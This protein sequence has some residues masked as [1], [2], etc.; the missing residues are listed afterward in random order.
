[1]TGAPSSPPAYE[2]IYPG[3][4]TSDIDTKMMST[5]QAAAEASLDH[6][7]VQAFDENQASGLSTRKL[8]DEVKTKSRSTPSEHHEQLRIAHAEKVKRI[9]SDRNLF[10][11]WVSHLPLN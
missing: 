4:S 8:E 6:K 10:F 5:V 2:E 7:C 3:L 11:I 9:R 1:M